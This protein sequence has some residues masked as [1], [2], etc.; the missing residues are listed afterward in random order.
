MLKLNSNQ[1]YAII[2]LVFSLVYLKLGFDIKVSFFSGSIGPH[3]WV[4][5]VASCLIALSLLLFFQ[6][7]TYLGNFPKINEWTQRIPFAIAIIVY[8]NVLPYL[9]FLITTPLLMSAIGYW[10][11][12]KP[13]KALI[14]AIVMTLSCYLLFTILLNISLPTGLWFRN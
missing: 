8:A 5:G 7:S 11:Q 1:H 2:V 6:P 10:F 4:I 3:H 13:I 14:S 9:G 12:A